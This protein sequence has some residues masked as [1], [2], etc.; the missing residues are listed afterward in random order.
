VKSEIL[1][2]NTGQLGSFQEDLEG[3]GERTCLV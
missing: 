2:D 1:K 3:I